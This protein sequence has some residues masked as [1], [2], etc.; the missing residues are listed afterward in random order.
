[1]KVRLVKNETESWLS[2][3]TANDS[4]QKWVSEDGIV[5]TYKFRHQFISRKITKKQIRELNAESVMIILSQMGTGKSTLVKEE[6]VPLSI[7]E[8]EEKLLVLCSRVAL[9]T[10]Y[11]RELA[12]LIA[13][14]LLEELT[15][16]GLKKLHSIGPVE[17]WTYQGIRYAL[18]SGTI[19]WKKFGF[20]VLDE[21]HHLVQ[22]ASFD[23]FTGET[24]EL[25]M[26]K[27]HHCRRIYLT[28]TPEMVL[29]QIVDAEYRHH[30]KLTRI[31]QQYRSENILSPRIS[32]YRFL[33]DFSYLEPSFFME[34][35][36]IL[37]V[38]RK[39]TN[40]KFLVCVDSRERGM[41]LQEKLGDDI[42]EYV[43][44]ALRSGEKAELVDE[45]IRDEKFE[46]QVLI[47]TSFLDVG[48]NLKD[49]K[50]RN[51]VVYS[52]NK[53]HFLQSLGRKRYKK[54]E[55][56]NLYIWVPE[57][58]KLKRMR[59]QLIAEL[60]NMKKNEQAFQAQIHNDINEIPHMLRTRIINGHFMYGY[61]PY[62]FANI[63]FRIDE[64][65]SLITAGEGS[66]FP[67]EGV[68]REYL[69][70]LERDCAEQLIRWLGMN[71]E[72]KTTQLVMLLERYL[73]KELTGEQFKAFREEF[74][75]IHNI[76]ELEE[77]W[78]ADRLPHCE[79]MNNFIAMCGLSYVVK[80]YAKPTRYQVER[81]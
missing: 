55:T 1:M 6:I 63:R 62:T 54:D 7:E 24:H 58:T 36:E 5:H 79:K 40:Q 51:V 2:K 26:K 76:L 28:G 43:D 65:S 80:A 50:L 34:D 46:K 45:I 69:R 59:G 31:P 29:D 78:R 66:A 21:V 4:K 15:P 70:W 48:V 19:D 18:Q 14:E 53:T 23:K 39:T 16:K 38:I 49:E 41:Q 37:D 44:S 68:A 57:L 52:T 42:A 33:N 25:L 47:A 71:P 73:G 56:V 60:Q 3:I 81:R 75:K 30:G 74:L 8:E 20:V 12:E 10:Q 72:S 22:D 35:E 13:P 11:K 17:V 61:N 32:I 77:K 64:L 9:A 67:E 27:L